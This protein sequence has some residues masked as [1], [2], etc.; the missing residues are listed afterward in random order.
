MAFAFS[1]SV[2]AS[3]DWIAFF[4]AVAASSMA[5]LA[6][7]LADGVCGT[8]L[9]ACVPSVCLA[10]TSSLVVA[11]SIAFLALVASASTLALAASFSSRV[12]AL[13]ASMAAFLAS[14]A[15]SMAFLASVFAV[16][17]C[18]TALIA[19]LPASF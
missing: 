13:S 19:S 3:L 7:G 17:V 11:A 16:G 1:S 8:S 6:A 14:A 5:C 18:G 10:V 9:M 2:K 15:W 12:K 4:L